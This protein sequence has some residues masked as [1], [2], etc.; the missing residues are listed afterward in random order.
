M[1]PIESIE[2]RN[3]KKTDMKVPET[4]LMKWSS[5]N[6]NLKSAPLSKLSNFVYNVVVMYS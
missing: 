6:I 2:V 1:V 4:C 5:V 3:P